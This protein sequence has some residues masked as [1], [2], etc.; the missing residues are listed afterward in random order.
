[1]GGWDKL[2]GFKIGCHF[3]EDFWGEAANR[4]PLVALRLVEHDGWNI[5]VF[6][7]RVDLCMNI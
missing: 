5:R 7:C 4:R 1:M 6:Y 2:F 3:D